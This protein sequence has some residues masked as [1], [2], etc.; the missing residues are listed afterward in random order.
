MQSAIV[1]GEGVGRGDI[2]GAAEEPIKVSTVLFPF[3]SGSS[4]LDSLVSSVP[5]P[6]HDTLN[7]PYQ[8]DL[9]FPQAA[10]PPWSWPMT[11]WFWS[12][13][14]EPDE[15]PSVVPSSQVS[16]R[17]WLPSSLIFLLL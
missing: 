12:K 15:P 7:F 17:T 4:Q 8:S 1:V 16:T 11:L 9:V 14:G 3:L 2:V 6:S 13:R 5:P 10:P